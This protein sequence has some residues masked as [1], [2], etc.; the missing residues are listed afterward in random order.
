MKKIKIINYRFAI[1]CL[2]GLMSL[3][4]CYDKN[5]KASEGLSSTPGTEYAPQMYHA[6]S[7]EPLTQ[8]VEKESGLN[9]WP[10]EKVGGGTS[11]YDTTTSEGHGEWY[12]SNYYN[13]FGMNMRMPV[14]GTIAKGKNAYR[15]NISADS[16]SYWSN[17]ASPFDGNEKAI[18]EGALLYSRYC[19]HCHGEA[20]DGKG[21][22]GVIFGGVPN[23]HSKAY[24]SKTKGNIYYTITYG[25][26]A[27]RSHAAQ[28]D[29]ADR[30]KI[31]EY[32][33]N[34]QAKVETEQGN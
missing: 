12:N 18:E 21:P 33:K 13:E 14:S 26:G 31:A 25:T 6:E 17:L 30:W 16:A 5:Q 8:I 19:Q 2:T 23:Y 3:T 4:S 29:P 27:M 20:G 10:Y 22:V 9:Y 15:Y 24:R 11:D 32:I 7:Y 34:W 28:V 1:M